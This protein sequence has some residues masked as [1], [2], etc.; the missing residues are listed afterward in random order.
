[1]GE[2]LL[3]AL[4][5]NAMDYA[6]LHP[7]K[8]LAPQLGEGAHVHSRQRVRQASCFERLVVTGWCPLLGVVL[9]AMLALAVECCTA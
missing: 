2:W 1:M 7:L 6:F 5:H 4:S 8:Q 9:T 3:R